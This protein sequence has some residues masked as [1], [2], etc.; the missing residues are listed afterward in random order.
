MTYVTIPAAAAV[1]VSING[2]FVGA[3]QSYREECTQGLA[4]ICS[5]GSGSVQKLHPL[6]REYDLQLRF[7]MPAG[8]SAPDMQEL[9]NFTIELSAHNRTLRFGGCEFERVF[10]ECELGGS[11]V[12]E[13][14]LAA[15]SR[16]CIV[17]RED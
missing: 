14:Q 11:I 10:T 1:R 17:G 12:C 3:L 13:V 2:S 8:S 5:I 6:R 15:I 9:S 16:R 4:R 7:L